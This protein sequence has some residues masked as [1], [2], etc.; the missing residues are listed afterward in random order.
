MGSPPHLS[1][2]S[3]GRR[4]K[5]ISAKTVML[6]TSEASQSYS[7]DQ[8]GHIY[9]SLRRDCGQYYVWAARLILGA[10]A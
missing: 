7:R 1:T 2:T 8:T 3:K 9:T 10:A 5:G 6:S 4:H